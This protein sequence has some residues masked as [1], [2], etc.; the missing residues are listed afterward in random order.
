M[1]KQNLNNYHDDTIVYT[2]KQDKFLIHQLNKF[3]NSVSEVMLVSEGIEPLYT[4]AIKLQNKIYNFKQLLTTKSSKFTD[5]LINRGIEEP[6]I[7]DE[8]ELLNI[9]EQVLMLQDTLESCTFRHNDVMIAT[10]SQDLSK[11]LDSFSNAFNKASTIERD[12]TMEN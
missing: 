6:T 7:D 1:K 8:L 12:N 4:T 9:Q 10:H 11:H 3:N 5:E 2:V